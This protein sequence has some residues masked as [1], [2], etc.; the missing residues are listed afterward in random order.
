MRIFWERTGDASLECAKQR[1]SSGDNSYDHN[2]EIFNYQG[3]VVLDFGCGLGRNLKYLVNTRSKMII[4]YDFPNMEKLAGQV[5]T[6]E[7]MKKVVWISPPLESGLKGLPKVDLIVATIVFQHFEVEELD[8]VLEVLHKN[9]TTNALM[10]VNSRGYID[11][12]AG[13]VW[14]H[15]LKKFYA[16]T[17]LNELDQ[18]ENHQKVIFGRR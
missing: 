18:S 12:R 15:L 4:G 11:E 14:P 1:I 7:E 17:P 3:K 6:K 2:L 16:L 13:N 5:L 10:Y 9:T 8:H